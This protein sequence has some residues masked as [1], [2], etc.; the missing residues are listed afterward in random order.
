VQ[1]SISLVTLGVADYSRAK[2]FYEAMGWS[3]TWEDQETAFFQANGVVIVLW[4]R[5]KLAPDTGVSDQGA[6]WSGI[7]L[8]HNVGSRDEVREVLEL[9][10]KAARRSRASPR[11]RSTAVTPECSV[12]LTDTPGRSRTIRAS[13]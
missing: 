1:Q 5:R 11:R 9:A 12:I 6:D 2:S 13:G 4:S 10:R 3:A 7:T 8:A